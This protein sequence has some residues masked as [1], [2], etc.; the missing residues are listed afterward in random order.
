MHCHPSFL[1]TQWVHSI[2]IVIVNHIPIAV[3]VVDHF[4]VPEHCY[5]LYS[6]DH[7]LP[8]FSSPNSPK[9]L[10]VIIIIMT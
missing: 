5:M 9:V 7:V 4:W 10:Y 1:H 8:F 6:I 3:V 2:T